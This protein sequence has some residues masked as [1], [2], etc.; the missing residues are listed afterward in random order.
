VERGE[1]GERITFGFGQRVE[2]LRR[3]AAWIRDWSGL[4]PEVFTGLEAGEPLRPS[5]PHE[6]EVE[7]ALARLARSPRVAVARRDGRLEV[8]L[9]PAGWG[10]VALGLAAAGVAGAAL[11]GAFGLQVLRG[12]AAAT[13]VPVALPL[14]LAVVPVALLVSAVHAAR[15]QV[16]LVVEDGA[17][18]I[19]I[20]GPL[21]RRE[22]WL[23]TSA[24]ADV[25]TMLLG[26]KGARW[27]LVV[28]GR[29]P[30]PYLT[31]WHPT[32]G[33][34]REEWEAVAVLLRDALAA[35]AG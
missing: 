26:G 35:P 3:L 22:R 9:L 13:P 27:G 5:A 19:E 28:L 16:R 12:S 18:R 17:L 15:R 10:G 4:P 33:R 6:S 11:A 20:H 21:G 29:D 14:L 32:L 2:V 25:R 31:L 34:R 1:T 30:R 7:R 8:E 24:I 23:R